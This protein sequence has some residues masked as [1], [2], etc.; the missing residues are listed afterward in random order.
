MSFQNTEPSHVLNHNVLKHGNL[1]NVLNQV[2]RTN[3]S[4]FRKRLQTIPLNPVGT[5]LAQAPISIVSVGFLPPHHQLEVSLPQLVA[6]PQEHQVPEEALRT[7]VAIPSVNC[8]CAG[9]G[10]L[11]ILTIIIG[12]FSSIVGCFWS[13]RIKHRNIGL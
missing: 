8:C 7:L 9:T 2:T 10:S 5:I 3:R 12:R 6:S 4:G 11:S 1:H 13:S